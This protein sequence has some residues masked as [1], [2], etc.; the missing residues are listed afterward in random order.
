MTPRFT[1]ECLICGDKGDGPHFGAVSC[2]AC[3]AFFR[4]AISQDLAHFCKTGNEKCTI[5]K[6]EFLSM[7]QRAYSFSD[8]QI[9]IAL[10]NIFIFKNINKLAQSDFCGC[11]EPVGNFFCNIFK[12]GRIRMLR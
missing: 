7:L 6:C 3:A 4:R 10:K 9:C 11:Y 12:F 8:E 2:K 5:D 1:L